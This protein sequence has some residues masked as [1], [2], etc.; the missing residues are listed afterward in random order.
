MCGRVE[1][2][3]CRENG[4]VWP[5]ETAGVAVMESAGTAPEC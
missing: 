4:D 3:E 5:G 2:P 1:L